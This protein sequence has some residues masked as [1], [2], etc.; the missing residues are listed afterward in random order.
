MRDVVLLLPRNVHRVKAQ[1]GARHPTQISMRALAA[2]EAGCAWLTHLGK[3]MLTKI[4]MVVSFRSTSEWGRAAEPHYCPAKQ[5]RAA[6]DPRVGG[7]RSVDKQLVLSRSCQ[8]RGEFGA[9]QHRDAQ[10]ARNRNCTWVR[11]SLKQANPACR[12]SAVPRDGGCGPVAPGRVLMRNSS[13]VFGYA[14]SARNRSTRPIGEKSGI[15]SN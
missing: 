8:K 5:R 4:L 2:V 6:F 13:S 11:G 14:S 12:I 9:K 7:W 1:D 15:G 3:V 10:Y